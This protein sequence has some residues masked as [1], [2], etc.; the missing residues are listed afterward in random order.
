MDLKDKLGGGDLR[1]IG[2][3]NNVVD[4]IGSQDEFDALFNCLHE[5]E[6]LIVMRAADAIEKITL[7]HPEYLSRHKEEIINFCLSEINIEFKWHLALLLAR[8]TLSATERD[9]VFEILKKWLLNQKESKIVRANA[10]QSLYQLSRQDETLKKEFSLIVG[11][12]EKENIP[13]LNARIRKI[14]LY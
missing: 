1:S 4:E 6:R 2:E 12:V 10:L 5:K 13:S 11:A 9:R 8:L 14:K 3:A 7:S